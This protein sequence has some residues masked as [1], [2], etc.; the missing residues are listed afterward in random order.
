LKTLHFKLVSILLGAV[1]LMNG[2]GSKAIKNAP[3][4]L[5]QYS[6]AMKDFEK[7]RYVSA[8]EGFQRV[9]FNFPGSTV[10]DTAQYY[11]GM[12]HF[13][14]GDYELAAVEF[15][16][17]QM[18]YPKSAWVDDAQYM[19]GI[20]YYKNTPRHYALDQE[21]LKKAIKTMEDFIIDNPDSP[22][23]EEV[24]RIILEARTKLAQK[25]YDSGL[26][27]FKVSEFKAAA[28]YFQLVVDDYTD[29]KYGAM[30]LYGLAEIAFKEGRYPDALEKFNNFVS[31]YPANELIPKAKKYIDKINLQI[32]SSDVSGGS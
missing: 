19:S 15:N 10:V 24:R 26:F 29:T 13:N 16:R 12:S 20:C 14:N 1:I 23:I 8:I 17:L 18:N 28:I 4:A 27:Y 6:Q 32:N 22:L 21:D 5:G 9:I 25:E 11:L 7:K 3:T 2:C 31:I 30:A